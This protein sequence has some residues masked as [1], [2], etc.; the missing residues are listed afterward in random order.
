MI[1]YYNNKYHPIYFLKKKTLNF[2]VLGKFL[3]GQNRIPINLQYINNV[4]VCD[5]PDFSS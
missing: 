4:E 2:D 3:S 1:Y 5:I